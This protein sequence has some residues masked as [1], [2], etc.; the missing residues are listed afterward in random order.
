M[1]RLKFSLLCWIHSTEGT[2]VQWPVR[3]AS[4]LWEAGTWTHSLLPTLTRPSIQLW[5]A[6]TP[7][8]MR[9][10]LCTPRFRLLLHDRSLIA[11]VYSERNLCLRFVSSLPL[12]DVQFTMSL[13]HDLP[14]V[15]SLGHCLYV[16]GSV[17][18]TGEKLLL[19]YN[20][21]HGNRGRRPTCSTLSLTLSFLPLDSWSEL[22]PALARAEADLP[23]L[24]FLGATDRLFVIGGNNSESVVTSFC[25]QS[26]RWGQVQC[27]LGHYQLSKTKTI[28]SS[29]S[30]FPMFAGAH[31]WEGGLCWSGDNCRWPGPPDV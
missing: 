15:S 16:L 29:T 27:F 8:T 31:S 6:M 11:H 20:T 30:S 25:L 23:A 19:Q 5:N 13:S 10:G 18:R 9:G 21:K 1:D 12:A 22:L 7:G 4:T 24:Y 3:A 28:L 26:N 17:Q 2:S 14:L